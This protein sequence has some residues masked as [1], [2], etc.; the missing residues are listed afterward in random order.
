MVYESKLVERLGR[1]PLPVEVI[2]FL[3]ERNCVRLAALDQEPAQRFTLFKTKKVKRSGDTRAMEDKGDPVIRPLFEFVRPV[4]PD[5]NA[6]FGRFPFRICF[7][8]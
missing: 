4:I 7:V 6:T 2:P 3:N 1:F 5:F 8:E